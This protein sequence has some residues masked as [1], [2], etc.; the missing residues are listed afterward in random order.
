[1]SKGDNSHGFKGFKA[2]TWYGNSNLPIV[3]E[4]KDV[5]EPEKIRRMLENLANW[6]LAN[7]DLS[8]DDL[9]KIMRGEKVDVVDTEGPTGASDPTVS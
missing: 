7:L 2:P 5:P 3:G 6:C 8:E 9:K 4:K 1:M